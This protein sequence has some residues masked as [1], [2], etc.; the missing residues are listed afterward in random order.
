ML[1]LLVAS[2][3]FAQCLAVQRLA[4]TNDDFTLKLLEQIEQKVPKT[5]NIFVSPFSLNTVL[6]MLMVG[7]AG[8]TYDEIFKAL[9]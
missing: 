5:E 6:S 7:S 8:I 4:Q 3:L 1:K 2:L 9:G